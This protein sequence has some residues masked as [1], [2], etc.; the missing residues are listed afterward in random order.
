MQRQW[1]RL[2]I[3]IGR[4]KS[5]DKSINFFEKGIMTILSIIVMI[6]VAWVATLGQQIWI[7]QGKNTTEFEKCIEQAAFKSSNDKHDPI[8]KLLPEDLGRHTLRSSIKFSKIQ[9]YHPSGMANNSFPGM[10]Y[11]K[12]SI[13]VAS[14][15]H[16]KLGITKPQKQLRGTYS[17]AIWEPNSDIWQSSEYP[18]RKGNT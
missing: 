13:I 10:S 8:V 15:Y 18:R 12:E 9:V 1:A 16:K 4:C 17:K 2:F 7:K 3:G 5:M 6:C 14:Q 11:H